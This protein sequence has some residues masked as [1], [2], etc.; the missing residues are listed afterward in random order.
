LYD[1]LEKGQQVNVIYAVSDPKVSDLEADISPPSWIL[2]LGFGGMGLL[3][4]LIGLWMVASSIEG[5]YQHRQLRKSGRITQGVIFDCW[6]ESD[7][8]STS[9]LV[10]YAF[11]PHQGRQWT[12]RAE[13][14]SSAYKA[15][16]PG[17]PV[18]VRYLPENPKICQLVDYRG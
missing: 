16:R 10:A 9:Y 3:F 12:T 15:L 13:Y 8:D 6:E 11:K 1:S 2:L 4:T 5:I 14:N 18:K 7:S 17:K